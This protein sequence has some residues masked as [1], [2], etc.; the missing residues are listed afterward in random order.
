MPLDALK[1]VTQ[2]VQSHLKSI[3]SLADN[4]HRQFPDMTVILFGSR[5]SGCAQ[6]YSD[7][8]LGIYSGQGI[9]HK[10]YQKALRL[11]S[12]FEDDSPYF[13]D[14]VN[15]NHVDQAFI[16]N[17]SKDWIFLTG[18]QTDWIDLNEKYKHGKN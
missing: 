5:A 13:I 8:D 9:T 14:L 2:N 16:N 11:K 12:D 7:W 17:I 15:L 3:A 10:D 18:S 1:D 6:Q 4:L